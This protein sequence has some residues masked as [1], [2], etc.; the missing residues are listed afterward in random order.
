MSDN[1]PSH[2]ANEKRRKIGGSTLQGSPIVQGSANTKYL[3]FLDVGWMPS[4]FRDGI[5]FH[6]VSYC[7]TIKEFENFNYVNV[8]FISY[9]LAYHV[10][11]NAVLRWT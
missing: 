4:A 11:L 2:A 9:S 1:K 3:F 5:Q 6:M 7:S 8:A 10:G